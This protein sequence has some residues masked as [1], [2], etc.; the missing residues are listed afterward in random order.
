MKNIYDILSGI[1]VEIPE[2]K[3]TALDKAI[4]ENYITINEA[5]K[6]RGQRDNYKGQL[7]TA[8]ESL[9]KFKGVDVEG[10]NKKITDL[11]TELANKQT[12]F[13]QALA[14]KEFDYDLESA[15]KDSGAKNVKAVKALLDVETLKK[16]QNRTEDIKTALEGIKTDNDYMFNSAEPIKN[17][18]KGGGGV[19]AEKT[20]EEISNMSFEEYK[21][22]RNQKD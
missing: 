9:E 20:I 16:S 2:D 7:D 4:K 11:T 21:K 12:A 22:Y 19:P 3:R 18:V 8:K 10:L 6:I 15:I 5:E 1:E 13:D 17:P 14:D